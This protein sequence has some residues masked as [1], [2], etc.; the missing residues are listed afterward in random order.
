M[1]YL[2]NGFAI[3]LSADKFNVQVRAVP[4]PGQMKALRA[5]FGQDW[6]L[7]WRGGYAYGIPKSDQVEVGFGRNK[8]AECQKH[9]FMHLISGRLSNVLPQ[10][11]PKYK[12]F[13]RRPFAFL[14]QKEEIVGSVIGSWRVVHDLVHQ[15][16]IRPRYE[17]DP[18][19]IELRPD[20]TEIAIFLKIGLN[21]SILAPLE[22]LQAAQIELAGLNVVRRDPG[23]DERRLVGT[24]A[25][26]QGDNVLLSE[27][28]DELRSIEA[29]RV[30]LEGSKASFT[31]CLRKLLGS[32][33]Q[34]FDDA[35]FQ[36]EGEYLLGPSLHKFLEKMRGVLKA[37]EEIRLAPDLTCEISDIVEARNE[38]HYKTVVSCGGVQYCFDSAKV[39]RHEYAWYGLTKFGPFDRETFSK[40]SPKILVVCPNESAGKVSQFIRLFR[41]GIQSEANSRFA[42]GFSGTF[43]LVNPQF[44]TCEVPTLGKSDGRAGETYWRT[45]ENHLAST[46]AQYDLALVVILDQHSGLADINSP[47]LR[48][49]AVLLTNGI[50]VQDVRLNTITARPASLQYSLQNLSVA[51]YAKMGGTPWTVSHDLTVDDEVVIGMG[52]VELTG[53]RFDKK[54][55]YMGITTVFRGDGNYLLSNVSRVCRYEEYAEELEASMLE[56]LRE[57]KRRNGW[58][59]GDTVRVVFHAHKPLRNV[60]VA[61]L[62][63]EC[64]ADIGSE[65]T[66]QFAFLTVTHDH[67]FKI[68]D[69]AQKGQEVNEVWKGVYAPNRGTVIQ[70]GRYT[71]LLVTNGLS[72]I[73]RASAPLPSPLLVNLH[74][75]S[76][77]VDLQYLP[78]QVLKFTSL[79]WRSTQPAH[80]PVTIYYSELI[81]SLLSRLK[82]IPGWSPAV[83][84]TKLRSSR[85]FL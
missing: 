42:K 71:R 10:R 25:S 69:T 29:K 58:Q 51:M 4:D 47:Y 18:R 64:I 73:K 9:E 46:D 85:W 30:Q 40:R 81:A 1:A 21:W 49:K 26:L 84:N 19:I 5:D 34:E 38:A 2:L 74:R 7:S 56:V 13:S 65:Q 31:R 78:E 22:D 61:Q 52:N 68:L 80:A 48:G 12:A 17:L 45:I 16:K 20:E 43:G 59:K 33:Y 15:F 67:P 72:Q 79:T 14:G 27:S 23:P 36:A 76:T 63:R 82:E 37:G 35:R 54:Q 28:F 41:D 11:F 50:P 70:L 8:I 44:V 32:K 24:I 75:E 55:R 57:V 77:Y 39:K 53:S 6:F 3:K 60:E 62:V 83:L 66:I